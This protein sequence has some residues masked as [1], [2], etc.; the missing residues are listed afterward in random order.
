MRS[1]AAFALGIGLTA[2]SQD[3]PGVKGPTGIYAGGPDGGAPG[4]GAPEGGPSEGGGP[5]AGGPGPKTGAHILAQ[6]NINGSSNT[7][8]VTSPVSTQTSGS[9]IIVSVGRG[10]SSGLASL[11]TDNMG[12][13]PYAKLGSNVAFVNY[14]GSGAA[15]YDFIGATGGAGHTFAAN[16]VGSDEVTI[17]VVEVKNGHVIQDAKGSYVGPG[18]LTSPSV[19]TTGP[20]TI[21]AFCWGDNGAGTTIRSVNNSFQLLDQYMATNGLSVQGA[22]ASLDVTAPGSYNV[23]WTVDSPQGAILF[24]VAVQ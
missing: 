5:G 12:N 18:T 19:T 6:R 16:M 9:T 1:I 20:A 7:P 24:I 14:P 11:P 23:T 3:T 22:S 21:V 4:R 10:D 2:C 8:L 15:L 13:T 17:I